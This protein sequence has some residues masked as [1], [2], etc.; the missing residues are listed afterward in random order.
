VPTL[1]GSAR[2]KVPAGTQSGTLFRLKGKGARQLDGHGHGDELI[3]VFVE[4]PNRL[5][6]EQREKL[7]AFARSCGDEAL[8]M[9]R[10]FLQR[11][12][13]IFGGK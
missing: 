10:S 13:E 3:R 1:D 11:A 2:V 7:E 8:P 12:K 6:D 4:I 5:N 9:R